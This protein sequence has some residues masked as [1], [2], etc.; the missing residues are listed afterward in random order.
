M[1]GEI[2]VL[3]T[4][5]AAESEK[6]ARSLVEENLAGCVNVIPAVNSI[7]VW[8]GKI[9]EESESLLLIKSHTRKFVELQSRIVE[10]H[11]YDC[12]EIICLSIQDGYKPYLDWLNSTISKRK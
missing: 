9:E 7:F 4:A 10:L 2:I 8:E 5:T 3:V 1:A 12:P 6:L 11:S